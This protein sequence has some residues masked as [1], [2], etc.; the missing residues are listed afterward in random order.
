MK[1]LLPLIFILF[2]FS[3][4]ETNKP[5]SNTSTETNTTESDMNEKYIFVDIFWQIQI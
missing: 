1:N 2:F 5:D 3:C 4:E